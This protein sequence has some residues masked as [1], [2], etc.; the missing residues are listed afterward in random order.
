MLSELRGL[1]SWDEHQAI[2]DAI[3]AG[4]ADAPRPR[5]ASHMDNVIA[6]I[7]SRL[8]GHRRLLTDRQPCRGRATRPT[9][10]SWAAVS[11]A[12]RRPGTWPSTCATVLV[13]R[14]PDAGL[15]ATGRS[16]SVLSKSRRATR[17]SARSPKPAGRSSQSP[18]DGFCDGSLLAP[19]GLVWVGEESDGDA[20]DSIARQG[21][22]L[23]ADV[24]RL[25]VDEVLATLP[26]FRRR[27]VGGGGRVRAGGDGDR[28][29]ACSCRASSPVRG[30]GGRSCSRRPRR[31]R[32]TGSATARRG[33]SS[34]SGSVRSAV[35][36][37]STPPARGATW[38]P[39]AA[40]SPRSDCC[41]CGAPPRSCRRRRRSAAWPLV[42]DVAGRYYLEPEAGGLLV[43]PADE[44]PSEPC[45]ARPEELDVALALERVAAAT[46]LPLRTVRT[47]LGRPADVRARPRAGDGR[48]SGR[49]RLLVAR[50][51]GWR[52]HQ[53]VAGARRDARADAITDS[54][55][56][57][58]V[59]PA[60]AVAVAASFLSD[61]TASAP[62]RRAAGA[63]T[64]RWTS[65][66]SS[67]PR[68]CD[69]A[70]ADTTP[71]RPRYAARR[72]ST[73][74]FERL[75][76]VPMIEVGTITA[77]RRALGDRRRDA[78]S[79]HHRRHHRRSRRRRRA[80]RRA[81]R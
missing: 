5:P 65:P 53:D 50:R 37:S 73:L 72:M 19:R 13:E 2:H 42:M 12:R 81:R 45:D 62:P 77:E 17:W 22:A 41:R 80:A 40:A 70:N 16:A 63:R 56:P 34:T 10:S 18:P 28:H 33:G 61:A 60:A 49:A 76:H 21:R 66:R 36:T 1:T 7:R 48:G 31:C 23:T 15:H 43:S 30:G 67:R 35:V 3:A 54:A 59:S 78:E 27:A 11:P 52:R 24:R 79:D 9:W 58:P 68:S 29:G 8:V 38:S 14:E 46:E 51:P 55:A 69:A 6:G 64:A 71:D 74:P 26:G 32:P 20:L 4:D 39:P 47:R 25:T 44:T 75:R 57:P